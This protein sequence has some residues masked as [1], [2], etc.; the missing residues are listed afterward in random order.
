M[1]I[2]VEE[3]VLHEDSVLF[4]EE[5]QQ[6]YVPKVQSFSKGIYLT[7]FMDYPPILLFFLHSLVNS[8]T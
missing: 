8:V 1:S 3:N 7:Y 6:N 5:F 2:I 4:D